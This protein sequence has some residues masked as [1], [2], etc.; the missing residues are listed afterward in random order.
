[1]ELG[2]RRRDVVELVGDRENPPS[3]VTPS[4]AA[5]ASGTGEFVSTTLPERISFPMMRMPAV[6]STVDTVG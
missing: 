2:D 5:R 1:V 4:L 3:P 6:R